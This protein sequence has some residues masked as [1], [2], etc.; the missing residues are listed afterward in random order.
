ME[1]SST[2]CP[3]C[4]HGNPRENR[5]CGACGTPLASGE[6]LARRPEN[7]P[8]TESR[9]LL[10]AEL[11]PVGKALAVGLAALAAEAGLAWLRSRAEGSDRPSLPTAR[12]TEPATL[13]HP[14][15]QSFE[16]VHAW[17]WEGNVESRFFAQRTV[18]S[19]HITNPTDGPRSGF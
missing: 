12:R 14:V 11:K 3:R 1:E 2:F 13:E 8:A 6:Q 9:G 17:L 15:Y 7:G 10:P 18:K 19:L 4:R 5:F 16:E